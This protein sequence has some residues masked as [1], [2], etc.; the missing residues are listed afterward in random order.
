MTLTASIVIPAWNEGDRIVE[1]LRSLRSLEQDGAYVWEIIVVDDGSQDDTAKLA[2][3]WSDLMVRHPINRGKGAALETGWKNATCPHIAFLDADLGESAVHVTQ[4]LRPVWADELDMCIAILPAPRVRAGFGFVKRIARK[5][6]QSLCGF[7]PSAPLSGQRALKREMLLALPAFARGFGIE[8]GL[9]IDAVRRGY[10][11]AEVEIPFRHR[12][13]D[14]SWAG[15]YHRG[16]QFA[17]VSLT[18]LNKWR[19]V[20]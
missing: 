16:K 15:F 1:T 9:T 11:V 3:P 7:E 12:E 13:T 10:R 19:T 2:S 5:G 8:V 20:R 6:I 18:L 17:A 4:L 14:R